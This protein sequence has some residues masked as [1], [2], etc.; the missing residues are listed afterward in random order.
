M[1]CTLLC[2]TVNSLA[3]HKVDKNGVSYETVWSTSTFASVNNVL[4]KHVSLVVVQVVIRTFRK[5]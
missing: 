2:M 1:V 4:K 3:H 5:E